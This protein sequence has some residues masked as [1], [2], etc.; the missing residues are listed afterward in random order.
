VGSHR[1]FGKHSFIK[2]TVAL[3]DELIQ[4]KAENLVKNGVGNGLLFSLVQRL[5]RGDPPIISLVYI[6]G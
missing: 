5:S 6:G 2:I 4:L 1:H 3:E